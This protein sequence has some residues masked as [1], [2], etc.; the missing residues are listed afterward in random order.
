MSY[1]DI[2]ASSKR[3]YIIKKLLTKH[4]VGIVCDAG[5]PLISD[6]GYKLVQECYFHKIKIHMPLDLPL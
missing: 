5:T 2:N 4:N 3:P 6:P 1:N